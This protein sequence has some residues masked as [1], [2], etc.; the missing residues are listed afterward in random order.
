MAMPLM[1]RIHKRKRIEYLVDALGIHESGM[2]DCIAQLIELTD[3]GDD[4]HAECLRLLA[5]LEG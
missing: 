3:P 4:L 2:R 5:A 1:W